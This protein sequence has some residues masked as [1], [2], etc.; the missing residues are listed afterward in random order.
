MSNDTD[1]RMALTPKE[2]REPKTLAQLIDAGQGKLD[3]YDFYSNTRKA[4]CLS[5]DGLTLAVN[6]GGV[7]QEQHRQLV[8]IRFGVEPVYLTGKVATLASSDLAVIKRWRSL[9]AM[10]NQIFVTYYN[11]GKRGFL[12]SHRIYARPKNQ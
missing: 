9:G 5:P 6:S 10:L 3:D 11:S 7:E 8:R 12:A 2:M 4:V 1:M